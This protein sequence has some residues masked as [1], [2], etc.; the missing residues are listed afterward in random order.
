MTGHTTPDR[1]A[2]GE[3]A[4]DALPLSGVQEEMWTAYRSAPGSHAYNAVWRLR[5]RGTVDV[6]ALEKA[7]AALQE[8]HE[9]LRSLFVERDG[10]PR[11]VLL[12][13]PHARLEVRDL[14]GAD[15]AT[16]YEVSR[17]ETHEPFRLET[18]GPLRVVLFRRSAQDA[19][20]VPTAHHIV[21]DY[22]SRSMMAGDLLRAYTDFTA[23]RVPEW[24]PVTGSYAEYAEEEARYLASPAGRAT[25]DR[26]RSALA[27]SAPAEL[28]LDRPRP[29]LR[30]LRGE[31]VVRHLPADVVDALPDAARAARTTPYAYTLAA[32]QAFVHRW[33]GQDDFLLGVPASNRMGRRLRDVVG[34]FLNTVPVRAR[35]AA[36]TTFRGAAAEA[37]REVTRCLVDGRYPGARLKAPTAGG[38]APLFH[39]AV[40][41]VPLDRM[42]LPVPPVPQ[43]APEGPPATYAGLRVSLVD[44]LAQQEGQLDLLLRLEQAPD[45]I[46]AVFSYDTDVFDRASVEGFADGFT[47][48]LRAAV[49]EPARQVAD[50]PL[51]D[52]HDLAGLP[53]P[54]GAG[55]GP[56]F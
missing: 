6:P 35:F 4:G 20:L 51:A 2:A 39:M 27:G 40:F 9:Q 18:E 30:A 44:D 33:T 42:K 10:L 31:T 43:G 47:R 55:E 45:G 29:V 1:R 26:W 54:V 12:D 22:V 25:A 50:V 19:V 13:G 36:D 8:R 49:T 56:A 37:G 48:M 52:E 21:S 32:F 7:V 11:R 17:R 34:C 28:P 14:P 23:G 38:R 53:A 5:I 46:T 3:T 16:L 41:L 24:A 15:E